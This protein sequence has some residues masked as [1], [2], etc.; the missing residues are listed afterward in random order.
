MNSKTNL[1]S[2][3]L[4]LTTELN[5]LE[6]FNIDGKEFTQSDLYQFI[7]SSISNGNSFIIM[8]IG[9]EHTSYALGALGIKLYPDY[10]I[11]EESV[12]E[13]Q[14]IKN[15]LSSNDY[16]SIDFNHFYFE[17]PH[18]ISTDYC[19][20]SI[21]KDH[22]NINE[23]NKDIITCMQIANECCIFYAEYEPVMNNSNEFLGMSKRTVIMES[24]DPYKLKDNSKR[25]RKTD[26]AE[27]F[28]QD[29]EAVTAY[30]KLLNL[31]ISE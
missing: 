18:T 23:L 7:N 24:I 17:I 5:K 3:I 22:I 30:V 14:K 16:D 20:I 28:L 21:S 19:F 10:K 8:A 6:K 26:T 2:K 31:E 1:D 27:K 29:K 15:E 25:I 9:S 4:F 13:W 11:D 12:F